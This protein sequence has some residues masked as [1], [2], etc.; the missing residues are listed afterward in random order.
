MSSLVFY[1]SASKRAF[2]YFQRILAAVQKPRTQRMFVFVSWP[3][4]QSAYSKANYIQ[5]AL[6]EYDLQANLE[7]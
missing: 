6:A 4:S 3:A 7:S 1:F 5:R 2:D